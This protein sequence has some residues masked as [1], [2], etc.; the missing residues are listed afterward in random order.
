MARLDPSLKH[1]ITPP[2]FDAN[3]LHRE[4]LVD[5]IHGEIARKLI[6]IA[7]PAGYGK[8]TLLADFAAH[9]EMPVC[10]VGLTEAD[11]DVMRL[12]TVL[13]ASLEKR[14]RR[15]KG[16]LDLQAL[17]G[18]TP[19]SL[20]NA[21]TV[22][23]DENIDETF[24]L[25]IDESDILNGTQQGLLFLDSF[26]ERI[27]DQLTII[28]AGREVLE[29][30]LAKLM[31]EGGLAGFG[32]HDLALTRPEL[33]Q[34]AQEAYDE[35][36]GDGELDRILEETGGWVTGVVMSGVLGGRSLRA[37][38]VNPRPMVYEYLASVVLNRQP[39]DLRQFMLN[40]AVLPVMDEEACRD[41][42]GES[43]SA[44]FLVRLVAD[45]LFVTASGDSP[46]TYE[47]HPLF[48]QFLIETKL[49]TDPKSYRE[50]CKAAGSYLER[51]GETEQGVQSYML[52]GDETHAFE[53]A[54]S[55]ARELFDAGRID[56][57][58]AWA[59]LFQV[60]ALPNSEIRLL[61]ATNSVDKGNLDAAE[62]LLNG[63]EREGGRPASVAHQSRTQLLLAIIAYRRGQNGQA[64][65]LIERAV[66]LNKRA[67][68]GEVA[69]NSL[70]FRALI[71]LREG[72]AEEGISLAR[73][74][75]E[76][77]GSDGP[78]YR[79]GLALSTLLTVQLGAGR[80]LEAHD[81]AAKAVEV[82][83][84]V[85]API[86]VTIAYNNLATIEHTI[87]R[88]EE[89]L[90]H[91]GKSL[92][93]AK[94][95]SSDLLQ[96][97]VYLGQADVFN[98][99]GMKL[100]AAELYSEAVDILTRLG[101]K[102]WTQTV[103]LQTSILHR[104]SGSYSTSKEWL[105]RAMELGDSDEH[106]T[107]ILMQLAALEV[108][109]NPKN[110]LQTMKKVFQ[111]ERTD[112][113]GRILALYLRGKVL[114]ALGNQQMAIQ[115]LN[116]AIERSGAGR[117][118]QVIASELLSDEAMLEFCRKYLGS[119]AVWKVIEGRIETIKAIAD[120]YMASSLEAH[121][122]SREVQLKAF[123]RSSAVYR[124]EEVKDLKPQ[125]KELLFFLVDQGG[126]EKDTLG[127]VFWPEHS[128]GRQAANLHMAVYSLRNAFG[129]EF[130][131]LEGALYSISSEV[132]IECDVKEFER[133]SR[134]AKELPVG[135]PRRLFALTESI[136]LYAG[137]FLQEFESEWVLKRRR[138]LEMLYLDLV[139]DH[140][141][142]AL[143]RDQPDK[144]ENLLRDALAIDPYRDDLNLR[145]ILMLGRLNR[146]SALVAHYQRYVD[147]LSSDLGLDPSVE[148]REAYSR[149]I[150]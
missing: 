135:D 25:L 123:G 54:E 100:Q 71:A 44:D 32:P 122:S 108:T 127:G 147:L 89:A 142:E 10:W 53:L 119:S 2:A 14:F 96:A 104:R 143:M 128:Q 133:A 83:S 95:A 34:L 37:I 73:E 28:A 106:S 118:E 29:V 149:M 129:K 21:F 19:E 6:V 35:S 41:V 112:E 92:E 140:A 49:A 40:S 23:I 86:P 56:T 125:V 109:A 60:E 105:K 27:P 85:R 130:V 47:Y 91:Y 67:K 59:D 1:A 16:K 26:L 64:L 94:L 36:L 138:N 132:A 111:D 52:A 103:C 43:K 50:L 57:L 79:K 63:K 42:L 39:E 5:A 146:R 58:S 98:D 70:R 90:D 55:R 101:D 77:L 65:R 107:S 110:A 31:A 4:R 126:A 9:T 114:L 137:P 82:A 80:I 84:R 33:S 17:S 48:R 45:G 75:L 124:G 12:A 99:L 68:L 3:K 20:S 81:T 116:D 74:A 11:R 121:P 117:M 88:F 18:S 134:I 69:V 62:R 72:R 115:D 66:H 150:S 102:T 113:A 136:R 76:L 93:Y 8:T 87:G 15:L 141:D 46:V 30:S 38:G 61:L 120:F 148:V 131:R 139:A 13:L 144:A 22:L 97:Q 7:A 78:D 51:I 145:Y 24:A